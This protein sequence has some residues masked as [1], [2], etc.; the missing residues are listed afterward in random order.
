MISHYINSDHIAFFTYPPSSG[1]APCTPQYYTRIYA[2]I[3]AYVPLHSNMWRYTRIYAIILGYV[4]LYSN[5]WHYT[6]ICDIILGYVALY[7]NMWHYTR[8]CGIILEYVA[9]YSNMWHY[10]RICGIILEYIN[11]LVSLKIANNSTSVNCNKNFTENFIRTV[12]F[13]CHLFRMSVNNNF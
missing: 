7:S 6:R 4:P 11:E 2:I 1:Y 9:L 10:T 12:P 13:L 8:I 3:L 5:M